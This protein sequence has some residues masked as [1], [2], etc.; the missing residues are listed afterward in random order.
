[1]GAKVSIRFERGL[2]PHGGPGIPERSLFVFQSALSA[3][4]FLTQVAL[5]DDSYFSDFVSIRFE[6]GLLP[7]V[8]QGAN[9]FAPVSVSIRFE[10]GLL[11]HVTQGA[12]A[13]APVSV[14]IRFERGLLPHSARCEL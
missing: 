6:R 8:T 4:F 3:A 5:K 2:L 10:R 12:N 13:F 7:H 1:M 11:P 9:A 14:S